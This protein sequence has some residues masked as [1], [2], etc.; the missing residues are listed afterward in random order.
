MSFSTFL[1]YVISTAAVGWCM[2]TW[3]RVH[4]MKEGKTLTTCVLE[5]SLSR[6]RTHTAAIQLDIQSGQKKIDNEFL[7]YTLGYEKALEHIVEALRP[8]TH[9]Q[10]ITPRK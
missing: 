8:S 6:A 4:G 5:T 7:C 9:F 1:S 10:E 3:G 2:F